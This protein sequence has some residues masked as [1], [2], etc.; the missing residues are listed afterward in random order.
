MTKSLTEI[1]QEPIPVDENMDIKDLENDPYSQAKYEK[2]VE[3]IA[4]YG[5]PESFKDKNRKPKGLEAQ[6]SLLN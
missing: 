6:R 4:K 2:A 3:L 1:L 5:I